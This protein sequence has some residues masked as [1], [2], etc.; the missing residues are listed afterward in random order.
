VVLA[1]DG[2]HGGAWDDARAPGRAAQRRSAL[3]FSKVG[4]PVGVQTRAD[5]RAVR[6]QPRQFGVGPGVHLA[7]A[8]TFGSSRPAEA[9]LKAQIGLP[10]MSNDASEATAWARHAFF[11]LHGS[12]V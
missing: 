7:L 11:D 5:R 6:H 12:A 10:R 3:V 9:A 4:W 2:Q 8:R 1:P